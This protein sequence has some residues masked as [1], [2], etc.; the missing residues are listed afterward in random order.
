[1]IHRTLLFL[2]FLI[3]T[4]NSYFHSQISSGIVL[5]SQE[6]GA[7]GNVI[8]SK[9]FFNDKHSLYIQNQA[10]QE[11]S[12]KRLSNGTI[13]YPA[14]TIDSIANKPKFVYF[15]PKDKTFYNNIINDNFESLIKDQ[16]TIKWTYLPEFKVILNYDCQKAE[17]YLHN[18]KYIAW[19]AKNIPAPYG[20]LRLNGLDG[21]ILELYSIDGL[22]TI[23]ANNIKTEEV[24]D[25]INFILKD[26]NFESALTREQ[27]NELQKKQLLLFQEELNAKL[28]E[29]YNKVTFKDLECSNC[30]TS[31]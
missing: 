12:V 22:L 9:L 19:F 23:K 16:P 26:Y 7:N 3:I 8:N 15:D 21:L 28:P 6:S 13:L 27:H 20:P 10:K 14:N 31:K 17:G 25:N 30:N 11:T 29:G 18:K 2:A 1:M 4:S 5:Y 24:N